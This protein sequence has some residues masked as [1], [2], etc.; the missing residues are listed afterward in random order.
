MTTL[1]ALTPDAA[2]TPEG[3]LR[4]VIEALAPLVRAAGSEDE[5]KAAGWIADRL[6]AA[7]APAQ[8]ETAKF[9]G[10][11][12]ALIASLAGAAAVGGLVGTTRKGRGLGAAIAGA[13]TALL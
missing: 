13:A 5:R 9:R 1:A 8:V 12:A 6:T 2:R 11:W 3:T 7:G 10:D 4:E